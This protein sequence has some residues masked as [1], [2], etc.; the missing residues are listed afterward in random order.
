MASNAPDELRSGKNGNVEGQENGYSQNGVT[1]LHPDRIAKNTSF[2]TIALIVQKV[3]SL[4]YFVYISRSVGPEN[5]GAYLSA[6]AI[7]T[8]LGFFIDLN[9][10]QALIRETAKRPEKTSQYLSAAITIK[11]LIAIFAYTLAQL[12]VRVFHLPVIVQHLVLVTGL[13]MILD[14]LT[15]S[16]YS[17]F[18]GHQ[19][20]SYE[21][22][23]TVV[24]KVIVVIVGIIGVRLGYG[25][26]YLVCAILLGSCFNVLY[27]GYFLFR[28]VGWIYRVSG[29]WPDIRYL[30]KIVFPWFALGGVFVTIYGYIDQLLLSNPLLVGERGSSYLSWYGTAYKLTY[31]FQFIPAAVVAAVFPAMSAYFM[32]NTDMLRKTFERSLRYLTLLVVPLS[33]GIIA[34]ADRIIIS[35]YTRA[36]SASIRP[37]QIL[38]IGLV[39]IFLNYPVGYLLNAT[40]RQRRNTIHIG[41]AMVTNIVLNIMLIPHFTFVGA[42]I[43]ST[44]SSVLLLVLNIRIAYSVVRFHVWSFVMAIGK[45]LVAAGTMC[46][47]ILFLKES[48]HPFVTILAASLW[49]FVVLFLI[50]GFS[51]NDG[52]MLY[53]V[54]MRKVSHSTDADAGSLHHH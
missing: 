39:F 31:A 17:I 50:R 10:S 52:K 16:F 7:T 33:L 28:R 2:L 21:A 34:L 25:V 27:S 3:L 8:V 18:R 4:G 47:G 54:V 19:K 46:I 36:Y 5:I 44:L 48:V 38:I 30:A 23:G 12:Y 32:T 13:I 15:L 37:L 14:S 20:L 26:L 6:L 43:S 35:A 42:A 1:I 11:I 49:Y 22:V 51:M 24:N 9:F 40:D 29:I 45:S 53:R 41:I